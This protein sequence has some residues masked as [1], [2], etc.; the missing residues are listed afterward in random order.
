[1]SALPG[2]KTSGAAERIISDKARIARILNGLKND[3]FYIHLV[4]LFAKEFSIWMLYT[5]KKSKQKFC[6][7]PMC[8]IRYKTSATVVISLC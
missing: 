3:P 1:M 7:N 4:S 6:N 2:T 5:P 8:F